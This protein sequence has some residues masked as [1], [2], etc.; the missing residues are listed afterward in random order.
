M[1]S[2]SLPAPTWILDLLR[3]NLL[4]GLQLLFLLVWVVLVSLIVSAQWASLVLPVGS[5]M[6]VKL[7]YYYYYSGYIDLYFFIILKVLNC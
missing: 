4:I 2:H 7:A 5:E 1:N 6:E 3:F